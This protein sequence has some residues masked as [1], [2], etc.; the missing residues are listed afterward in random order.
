MLRLAASA[1]VYFTWSMCSGERYLPSPGTRRPGDRFTMK[2]P[3]AASRSKSRLMR[4]R[5]SAGSAP[6]QLA[7]GWIAPYSCGGAAKFAAASFTLG[8]VICCHGR[9]ASIAVGIRSSRDIFRAV[10]IRGLFSDWNRAEL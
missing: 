8:T 10:F 6:F 5:T 1:T 3:F 2:I 9:C 7:N 4:A